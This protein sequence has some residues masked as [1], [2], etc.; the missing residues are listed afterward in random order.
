MIYLV[1]WKKKYRYPFHFFF[2][3]EN[4]QSSLLEN[5]E[6]GKKF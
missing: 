6:L 3:L 1:P 4:G 2:Y 5:D